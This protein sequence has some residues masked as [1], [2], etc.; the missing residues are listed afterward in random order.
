MKRYF[1]V[2]EVFG[3]MI[4]STLEKHISQEEADSLKYNNESRKDRP[5]K[6]VEK[7]ISGS[8]HKYL[9]SKQSKKE[10]LFVPGNCRITVFDMEDNKIQVICPGPRR[11]LVMEPQTV[12]SHPKNSSRAIGR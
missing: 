7:M 3:D 9:N 8:Y 2:S 11:Q 4:T 10:G 12:P 5:I 6:K 1:L